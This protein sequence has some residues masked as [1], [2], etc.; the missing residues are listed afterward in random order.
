[1]TDTPIFDNLPEPGNRR[2]ARLEV[3][4]GK[5]LAAE[6]YVRFRAR[7]GRILMTT[8]AYHTR[9]NAFRAARSI[10]ASMSDVVLAEPVEVAK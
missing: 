4:P 2:R 1:M 10:R 6:W 7:N 8:E 9:G 3:F 5:G